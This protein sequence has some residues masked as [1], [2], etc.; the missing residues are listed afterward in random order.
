[1]TDAITQLVNHLQPATGEEVQG[2][3][4][5][6]NPERHAVDK[7]LSMDPRLQRVVINKGSMVDA[8][9]QTAVLMKRCSEVMRFWQSG[10]IGGD[11]KDGDW[12]CPGCL[13]IQ[14]AKNHLCRKCGTAQPP[15]SGHKSQAHG[16]DA[17]APQ[18]VAAA[19]AGGGG[20][21]GGGA[22]DG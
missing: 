5:R 6:H 11:L 3:L 16:W 15:N 8:R 12:I 9:D 2:F 4:S 10:D 13:D 14:F 22:D 7:F 19:W 21:G 18:Q 17:P 1:M 20:G